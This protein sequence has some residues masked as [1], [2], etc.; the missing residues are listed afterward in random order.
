MMACLGDIH[1]KD[2]RHASYN[3]KAALKWK[4]PVNVTEIYSFWIS[5]FRQFVEGFSCCLSIHP[6]VMEECDV[7]K[8]WGV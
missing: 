1:S 2:H 8:E 4:R 5:L 3:D 7:Y 6:L